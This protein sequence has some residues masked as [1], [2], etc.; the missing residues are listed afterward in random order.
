LQ[1]GRHFVVSTHVDQYLN[2]RRTE[3]LHELLANPANKDGSHVYNLQQLINDFPQSGLLQ[4]LL[5][6]ADDQRNLSKAAVYYNPRLLYKLN[7]DADGFP[8]LPADKIVDTFAAVQLATHA[9][10][11]PV[12]TPW[13]TVVNDLTLDPGHLIEP[14]TGEPENL[15]AVEALPAFGTEFYDA[16][17]EAAV[18]QEESHPAIAETEIGEPLNEDL[19]VVIT[20]P[21]VEKDIASHPAIA[22]TEANEPVEELPVST[23][24][25]AAYEE[26][27][28]EPTSYTWLNE[29]VYDEIQENIN[30]VPEPVLNTEIHDAELVQPIDDDVYDEIVGIDD[31]DIEQEFNT[32]TEAVEA[33]VA[34]LPPIEAEPQKEGTLFND[35]KVDL[36]DDTEK[37]ILNNIAATD[38]FVFDRALGGRMRPDIATE[39][40]TIAPVKVEPIAAEAAPQQNVSR[41]HDEKMPY[42]FMWWLDK[43]R[44]EY[45]STYQP[46]V[47]FKLDTTE[48]I[49]DTATDELQYQYYE[50][51]FHL[52]SVEELERGIAL[53]E[54]IITVEPPKRKEDVIIERF[55][56]EVPQIKP[57]SGDKLD[58]ENKARK[59]SEDLN[60]LVTETLAMVYADQ[61]LYPKAI[62]TYKK[63]MLKFPEKSR[64]FAGQIEQLENKTS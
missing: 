10:E 22:E 49:K 54:P 5:C 60:E 64:Y 47:V 30:V 46:Y 28:F 17:D 55:I 6:Y 29:P 26:P 27:L 34:D 32:H 38:F 25:F 7:N 21:A 48:S 43:T 9:S 41:Y 50:N 2:N 3:L 4:A 23:A 18:Q 42:S 58:N 15:A 37:L 40:H 20:E 44:K 12:S 57:Q 53:Q 45:A 19:P 56:Q 36:N 31:I 33:T 1:I 39:Q 8:I 13:E 61:M 51:I 16:A 52:T 63:L 11:E 62:A 14:Y 24:E 59:S 35:R